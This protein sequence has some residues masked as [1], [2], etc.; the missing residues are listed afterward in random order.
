MAKPPTNPTCP[1]CGYDQSG[2]VAAWTDRCP[3]G[4]RCPECGTQFGWADLFDPSRRGIPWFVEHADGVRAKAARTVPTLR[5]MAAPWVFW[6]RVSVL[7][8][9]RP[10]HAVG[11]LL[12]FAVVC[13]AI[14]WLPVSLFLAGGSRWAMPG[15]AGLVM[16]VRD[17]SPHQLGVDLVNGLTWPFFFWALGGYPLYSD[18]SIAASLLIPLWIGVS[19]WLLLAV[20]PTTRRLARLRQGHLLRAL[21]LQTAVLVLAGTAMRVMYAANEHFYFR[22]ADAISGLIMVGCYAWSLVW[23]ACAVRIGWRIR[24]WTLFVLGHVV[25][26]L[27]LYAVIVMAFVIEQFLDV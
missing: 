17:A 10:A 6:S 11:W 20:L 16:V 13:H 18:L 23:W 4:G 25:V 1:R 7:S 26:L 24:S 5:R 3:V 2:A 27:S 19:W 12:L 21:V 8:A 9:T 14:V 15:W 22:S